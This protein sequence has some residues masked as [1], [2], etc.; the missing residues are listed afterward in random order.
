MKQIAVSD[1]E[2]RLLRDHADNSPFKL[3]RKKANAILLANEGVPVETIAVVF[4]KRPSTIGKWQR[5]WNAT[6]MASVVTGHRGNLNASRLTAAQRC[7][8]RRDLAQPPEAH[9]LPTGFWDVPK[10]KAHLSTKFAVAYESDT[11]YHYVLRMAGLELKYPDKLD[12]RR[13]DQAVE[14]RM[15]EIRA[16]V[17]PLLQDPDWDVFAAD[18]VRLDQEAITRR[19]WLPVGQPTILRVDRQVRAQSYL[20]L[21]NQSDGACELFRIQWQKTSEI[22]T[23]LEAFLYA[24]PGKRIAIVWDNAAFH[25]SRELR[26]QLK[27]GGALE[28]V[29]LIA[30]PPCAPDHNPIEHVWA[31]A[32]KNIANIQRSDFDRTTAAF[33]DHIASRTFKYRI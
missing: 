1:E 27:T 17:A 30:M 16:E 15:A 10:L 4:G 18:E 3:V 24:H 22:I 6:R 8:V 23:A 33:E 11:S 14:A 32:K 21:L 2:D 25:K 13:D 20:G 28:R 5:L 19:A 26:G 31:D 7:Q 29:H 12:R 9:G